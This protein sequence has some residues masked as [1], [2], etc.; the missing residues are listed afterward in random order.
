MQNLTVQ[1]SGNFSL[2]GSFRSS[3]SMVVTSSGIA[4]IAADLPQLPPKVATAALYGIDVQTG[5]PVW[6]PLPYFNSSHPGYGDD[7]AFY[8]SGVR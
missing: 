4:V 7:V 2:P 1:W 8:A 3:S 5:Q 6:G